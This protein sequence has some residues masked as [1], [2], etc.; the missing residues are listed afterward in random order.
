MGICESAW[1]LSQAG[2]ARKEGGEVSRGAGFGIKQ[3]AHCSCP[4]WD[5]L[6]AWGGAPRM[7]LLL[8]RSWEGLEL[9]VGGGGCGSGALLGVASW[10]L[11]LG[12]GWVPP[13]PTGAPVLSSLVELLSPSWSWERVPSS[14]ACAGDMMECSDRGWL[15]VPALFG[16]FS[17]ALLF[18]PTK[19]QQQMQIEICV[20]VTEICVCVTEQFKFFIPLLAAVNSSGTGSLL[21]AGFHCLAT[22]A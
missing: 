6:P 2:L 11:V 22:P 20:C 8:L 19:T 12:E 13:S 1:E 18:K 21:S 10:D 4:Q 9:S 16:V 15:Y 7:S 14:C 17:Q 5:V 3:D